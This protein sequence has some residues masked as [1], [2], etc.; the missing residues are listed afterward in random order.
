MTAIEG[1]S[2]A[3]RGAP[4]RALARAAIASTCALAANLVAAQPVVGDHEALANDRP[5]AWAL[6]YLGGTTLF[7]SFG[8]GTDPTGSARWT[9]AMDLGHVPRLSDRQRRVGF[10]GT[11][12]ENLN[13]SPLFGRVRAGYAWAPGWTAEV[14]YTPPLTIDGAK[15]RNLWAIAV[16]G[17]WWQQGPWS[18]GSRLFAQTGSVRGD[19]TCAAELANVTDPALNPYGCE[20]ASR[21]TIHLRYAGADLTLAWTSTDWQAHLGAGAIRTN[22]H[23]QVDALTD[24]VR[25]RSR[26]ES[27]GALGYV[28]LGMRWRL[29]PAWSVASEVLHVPLHV[30]RAPTYARE[31][32]ALTSL[33]VQVRRVW[34]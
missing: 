31:S 33:R 30:R 3:L 1:Q 4:P 25:D 12:L 18:L 7:T 29:D 23:V 6:R 2:G 17:R 32:D 15:A 34:R 13:K 22:F 10:N 16:G 9:L 5:E 14:A 8:E 28:A 11:K 27:K 19:F 24:G 26:R 20:A 21:D